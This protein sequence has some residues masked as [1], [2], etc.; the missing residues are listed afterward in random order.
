MLW[1]LLK[2]F[3]KIVC[4]CVF[5][6]IFLDVCNVIFIKIF[7][8]SVCCLGI[9]YYD[10]K[11]MVENFRWF[12]VYVIFCKKFVVFII[13]KEFWEFGNVLGKLFVEM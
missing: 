11:F 4:E 2:S 10:F 3:L 8:G 7:I 13:F 9:F 6:F 5:V 1:R 12:F